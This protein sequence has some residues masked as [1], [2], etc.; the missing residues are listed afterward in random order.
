MATKPWRPDPDRPRPERGPPLLIQSVVPF[1]PAE[2]EMRLESV[3]S[4]RNSYDCGVFCCKYMEFLSEGL[5]LQFTQE[6]MPL[7]RRRMVLDICKNSFVH[8]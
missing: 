5:P 8:T 2:W 3:P 4:Q 6:D 1:N 7:L